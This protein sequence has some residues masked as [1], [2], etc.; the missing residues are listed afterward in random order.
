[1][2]GDKNGE[3]VIVLGWVVGLSGKKAVQRIMDSRVI[4]D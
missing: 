3:G 4:Y 1:V 2:I